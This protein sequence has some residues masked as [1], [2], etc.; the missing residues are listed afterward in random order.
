MGGVT[1]ADDF[2]ETAA[3]DNAVIRAAFGDNSTDIRRGRGV[4]LGSATPTNV[5]VSVT[6]DPP[7]WAGSPYGYGGVIVRFVDN[8]NFLAAVK[9][10]GTSRLLKVKGGTQTELGAGDAGR[11]D[12]QGQISLQVLA[13]GAWELRWN[14]SKVAGGVDPDTA[15]GGALDDGKSGLID[16]Y[17]GGEIRTRTY[18]NFSVSIPSPEPIV[19]YA[20][21]SMEFNQNGALREIE[22][23]GVYG[24]PGIVSQPFQPELTPAGAEGLTNRILIFTSRYSP[25]KGPD[26]LSDAFT[27]QV[28]YEPTYAFARWIQ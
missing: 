22:A 17:T 12:D 5:E 6:V 21:R 18:S 4:I 14:G 24:S 23:G 1:D 2:T 19:C 7:D 27:V 26:P 13:S 15:T 3:P 11:T 16:W 8:D 10:R 25:D 20:G 28:F 9:Y